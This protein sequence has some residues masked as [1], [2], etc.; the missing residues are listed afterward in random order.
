MCLFVF[1][2]KACRC[3]G[4]LLRWLF[5]SFASPNLFSIYKGI[6]C[7][8]TWHHWLVNS[9]E[10]TQAFGIEALSPP[11]PP[12]NFDSNIEK[13]HWSR[14]FFHKFYCLS[15][16]LRSHGFCSAHAFLIAQSHCQAWCSWGSGDGVGVAHLP[17]LRLNSLAG[18][19]FHLVMKWMIILTSH[20]HCAPGQ[21]ETSWNLQSHLS[22][23]QCR[24][25]PILLPEGLFISR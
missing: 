22:F 1:Y 2:L 6:I 25:A 14:V 16:S 13:F 10:A 12:L 11:L 20:N 4:I 19:G 21:T 7:F 9:C 15:L 17:C 23:M 3:S 5:W 24:H 18:L 8:W